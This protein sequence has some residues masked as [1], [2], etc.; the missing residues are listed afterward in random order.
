MCKPTMKTFALSLALLGMMA[1]TTLGQEC[2]STDIPDRV[3]CKI[4]AL[5]QECY[6]LECCWRPVNPNPTNAPW[7]FK[8]PGYV[9]V[10]DNITF[11]GGSGGPGFDDTIYNI[12]YD[13]YKSQINIDGVGAVVASPDPETPGGSYYYHWMRDGALSMK[14][15]MEINDND[16]NAVRVEM[17]AYAGWVAMV[18]GKFDPNGIDV[19]VEPKFY[20]PSGDPYDGGWCRPQNDGPALRAMALSKY[21]LLKLDNGENDVQTLWNTIKT[22][23]D[24]VET[25]WFTE[26]CDLWE[27]VRS[28]DFYFNRAGYVYSLRVA[29]DL[30]DRLGESASAT[31][32]RDLAGVIKATADMHYQNGYIYESTNRLWDGAVL[33]SIATFGEADPAGAYNA[34]SSE[35][36]DTLQVLSYKFCEEY[37]INQ[38]D[39]VKPGKSGILIGRYPGDSYAGGNPW[40]L[41]TAVTAEVFYKASDATLQK[42][43][44]KGT[45]YKVDFES[46]RSWL[47]LTELEDGATA[48]ELA[49]RMLEAG[50]TV[51]SRLY[52]YVQGDGGRIDEQIDKN[53][54]IQASAESLTWS[55]ANILH[56]L[57]VRRNT[58][59]FM[60]TLKKTMSQ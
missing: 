58:V 44:A 49:T 15:W 11:V 19:R 4:G 30:A 35:A 8:P 42:I 13:N 12:M 52:E 48:M 59:A 23:L 32:Y 54:G 3:D 37:P 34:D 20:I 55:Y 28:D 6:D 29:A 2:D 40:Q 5:E 26:G 50:D 9:S 27:E 18:Q 21:A 56:S 51:M 1:T 7:C 17:D 36:A 14:D 33:H 25:G 53:T 47:K 22:D 41:L 16:L 45:D 39:I 31:T 60:E 24:W 46:N 10:C 38:N 57:T 43:K